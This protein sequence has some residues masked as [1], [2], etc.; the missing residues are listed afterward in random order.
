MSKHGCRRILF[1]SSILLLAATI[2][3]CG[4]S[5]RVVAPPNEVHS[6][7]DAQAQ[8]PPAP[9]KS[10]SEE[11]AMSQL[12]EIVPGADGIRYIWKNFEAAPDAQK[13]RS[14]PLGSRENGEAWAFGIEELGPDRAVLVIG[15]TAL[16]EEGERDQCHACEGRASVFFF[17]RKTDDQWAVSGSAL[18]VD[19]FGSHGGSGKFDFV[20]LGPDRRGFVIESGGTFQ[21]YTMSSASIFELVAGNK[22]EARTE[23]FIRITAD[24]ECDEET[25][26]DCYSV[27][28]KWQFV[29]GSNPAAFDLRI[30]F[31]GYIVDAQ[32][33][34]E[35]IHE[36]ALYR[37]DEQIFQRVEGRNPVPAP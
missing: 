17:E 19:R 24:Y 23:E 34:R 21:G 2:D 31:E 11:E 22:V 1:V 9:R 8:Q 25:T 32:S 37:L 35:N 5:G 10:L 12:F 14:R 7:S 28:G 29:P 3:A 33:K 15:L 18:H 6:A 16:D 4:R 13:N 26:A 36:H 20:K 30:D 27:E